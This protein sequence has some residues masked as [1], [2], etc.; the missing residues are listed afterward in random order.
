MLLRVHNSFLVVFVG[1]EGAFL[2]LCYAFYQAQ[3]LLT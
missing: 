1:L 2:A 3:K